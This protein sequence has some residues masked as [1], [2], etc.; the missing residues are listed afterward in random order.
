ML[1]DRITRPPGSPGCLHPRD[2]TSVPMAAHCILFPFLTSNPYLQLCPLDPSS[3]TRQNPQTC[4]SVSF[5]R[6]CHRPCCF[7]LVATRHLE[8]PSP[9][10]LTPVSS[11]KWA[12]F[13]K[14]RRFSSLKLISLSNS[15]PPTLPTLHTLLRAALGP[16][17]GSPGLGLLLVQAACLSWA[18]DTAQQPCLLSRALFPLVTEATSHLWSSPPCC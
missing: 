14:P 2:L 1:V 10:C 11:M 18:L 13:L 15:I 4:F 9:P 12:A 3:S 6:P 17:P 16:S 7:I 8:L 5:R